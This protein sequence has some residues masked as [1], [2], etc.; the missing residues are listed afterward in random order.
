MGSHDCKL[1]LQRI[2]IREEGHKVT[3]KL[4]RLPVLSPRLFG[5]LRGRF[6]P[7]EPV[8]DAVNMDVY[9]NAHVSVQDQT[10]SN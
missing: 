4:A 6:M 5:G 10:S 8:G 7:F 2:L 9:A 3:D 1:S